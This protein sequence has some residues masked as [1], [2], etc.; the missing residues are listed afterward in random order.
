MHAIL[1]APKIQA[2]YI[3]TTFNMCKKFGY[4]EMLGWFTSLV[5]RKSEFVQAVAGCEKA[6]QS[7]QQYKLADKP[8]SAFFTL[9]IFSISSQK[10][11]AFLD[12]P[13]C[14][15]RVHPTKIRPQSA[16]EMQILGNGI[17]LLQMIFSVWL[18]KT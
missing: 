13:L 16:G 8:Y 10:D 7:Y 9:D 12:E 3:D 2:S 1:T 14:V 5:V 6:R 11:A 15:N 18:V 4:L 17:F